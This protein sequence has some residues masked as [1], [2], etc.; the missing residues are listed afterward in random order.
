MNSLAPCRR[1]AVIAG[2]LLI[3]VMLIVVGCAPDADGEI[4]SPE[5]GAR[6]VLARSEGDVQVEPTPVPPKLAE[7][8]PDLVF[9]GLPDDVRQA[10]EGADI[11]A[12][13]T[14]ALKY[15]CLGCHALDPNEVKTGPT[16]HNSGDLAVVRVPEK[17]PAFYLYESIVNPN[18]YVVEGYP[19]NIMPANFQDQMTPQE[20]ADMVA[21]LLQQ[22]GQP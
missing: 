3:S 12:A 6:L 18:A 16:W 7:L 2:C 5:L 13:E 11:G 9:A 4:I 14:I 20:I 8:T 22:N 1:I 19:G 21:Y 17:S 15:G 10:V